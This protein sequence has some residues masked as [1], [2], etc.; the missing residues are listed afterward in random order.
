MSYHALA[1]GVLLLHFGFVAFVTLGALLLVRWPWVAWVHLPAAVWGVL[2]ELTGG[3]CPLTPLE[4]QLRQKGGETGYVG[5]FIDHYITA[6]L[7]PSGLTRGVQWALGGALLLANA[8]LYWRWWR[9]RAA[10]A[11]E[12]RAR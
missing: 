10:W 1:D 11:A 7:Y 12:R 4:Q 5:G 6:A 2:I 9:R 3:V 8:M